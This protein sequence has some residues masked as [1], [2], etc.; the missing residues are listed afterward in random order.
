MVAIDGSAYALLGA[1]NDA[2]TFRTGE[3]RPLAS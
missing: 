2:K 3:V 1:D